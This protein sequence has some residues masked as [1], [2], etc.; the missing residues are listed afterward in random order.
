MENDH[1][2]R[3][4]TQ[5]QLINIIIIIIIIIQLAKRMR[6]I[7]LSCVACL[8]LSYFPALSKK[9]GTVFGG[10]GGGVTEHKMPVLI[11]SATFV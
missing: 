9:K 11:F 3:V 1:C 8:V 2:H 4:S 6:R 10:A 7:I 5:L